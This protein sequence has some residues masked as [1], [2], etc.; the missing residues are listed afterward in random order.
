MLALLQE[1]FDTFIYDNIGHANEIKLKQSES[2]YQII[3]QCQIEWN[4]LTEDEN[5]VYVRL[6]NKNDENDFLDIY[7]NTDGFSSE[8]NPFK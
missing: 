5:W 8:E 7:F 6:S 2:G 1:L 3:G 4:W